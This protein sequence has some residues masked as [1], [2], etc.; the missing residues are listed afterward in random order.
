MSFETR[1]KHLLRA[2]ER[3]DGEG[4]VRLANILRKMAAELRPADGTLSGSPL[5]SS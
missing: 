4:N 5:P 3:A 2:A 1:V